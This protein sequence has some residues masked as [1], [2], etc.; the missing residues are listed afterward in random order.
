MKKYYISCMNNI[1][2]NEDGSRKRVLD[3]VGGMNSNLVE[4]IVDLLNSKEKR[5]RSDNRF[6]VDGQYT[7]VDR[8]RVVYDKDFDTPEDAELTCGALNQVANWDKGFDRRAN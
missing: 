5:Q 2:I 6:Y 3:N 1:C 4:E 7:V 8:M